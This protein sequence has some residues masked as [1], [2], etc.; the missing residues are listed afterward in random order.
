MN[1]PVIIQQVVV[2]IIRPDDVEQTISHFQQDWSTAD[3][4]RTINYLEEFFPGEGLWP[5]LTWLDS[6]S[7]LFVHPFK[8]PIVWQSDRQFARTAITNV[9]PEMLTNVFNNLNK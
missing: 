7:F 6:S 9:G 4:A 3:S 1:R 2:F 5:S 8:E